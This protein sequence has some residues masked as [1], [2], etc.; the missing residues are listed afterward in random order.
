MRTGEAPISPRPRR[1]LTLWEDL[2]AALRRGRRSAF[3]RVGDMASTLSRPMSEQP[4]GMTMHD[5][6]NPV[7][8][9][10]AELTWEEREK[11]FLDRLRAAGRLIEAPQ[12]A[13]PGEFMA[14]FVPRRAASS[15]PRR[16]A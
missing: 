11:P 9:K 10:K 7:P 5:A 6:E 8:S 14:T 16:K 2:L 12:P 4:V 15:A 1:D 13:E 3:G